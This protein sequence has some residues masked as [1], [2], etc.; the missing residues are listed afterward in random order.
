[1]AKKRVRDEATA[2]GKLEA[3]L[4]LLGWQAALIRSALEQLRDN[5]GVGV[6]R[7]GPR[8]GPRRRAEP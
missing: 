4:E 1:M 3:A 7:R 8:E 6:G 2:D 5:A